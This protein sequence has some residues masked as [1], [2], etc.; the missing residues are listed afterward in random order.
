MTTLSHR[1]TDPQVATFLE[2]EGNQWFIRNNQGVPAPL[3]EWEEQLFGIVARGSHPQS[4]V[5]LEVGSSAGHRLTRINEV[6][7]L[8]AIGVDPSADAIMAGTERYGDFAH[9]RIGTASSIP[10]GDKEV[11]VLFFGFCLY[12]VPE[13]I[14]PE[15]LDE[16]R[17]V[18]QP[19]GFVA[20][21]DFDVEQKVSIPYKHKEGLQSYRRPYT[22]EFTSAGFSLV[23][24]LPIRK[25]RDSVERI[26][27]SEHPM[28]RV[29]AW[30]FQDPHEMEVHAFN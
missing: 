7:G 13:S 25:D 16:V 10:V 18:L 15:V 5:F 3:Q 9:F 17:R 6:L 4:R 8:S 29:S 27:R 23:A 28:D 30:L 2:G 21:L 22:D 1:S 19:G 24:K 12:L 26:T 20:I 11:S 14:F